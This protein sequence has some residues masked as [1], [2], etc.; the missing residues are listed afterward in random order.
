MPV[1]DDSLETFGGA[2][3]VEIPR[4]QHLLRFICERGFE[5]HTA[6][7]LT[8]SAAPVY[9]AAGKYLGWDTYWHKA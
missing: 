9:E 5:H 1:A 7:N 8:H 3:V 4:M 6:A 2:G